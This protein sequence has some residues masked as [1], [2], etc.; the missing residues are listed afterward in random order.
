MIRAFSVPTVNEDCAL[1]TQRPGTPPALSFPSGWQLV[2]VTLRYVAAML[3]Y[4]LRRSGYP[5]FRLR[6]L[7]TL[8]RKKLIA[9]RRIARLGSHYYGT[10]MRIPRWPSRAFDR[11]VA[12]GGLNIE[13]DIIS[14]KHQIDSA[15]LSITRKCSYACEHCSDSVNRHADDIVPVQRWI[16]TVGELQAVGTSVIILSG[17]E[18][19][20]RYPALL[21]ILGSADLNL[22][23]FHL[24]TSGAGVTP[25]RAKELAGKGLVAAG[26][27][28][29]YP[30]AARQDQF[31]GVQG[32]FAA[33][34][35][36]LRLFASA[37]VFTYTNLCLQK[38]L[39]AGNGLYAYL[40]LAKMLNVGSVQL[41]E[42]KPCGKY[43]THPADGLFS[44]ADRTEVMK[45]FIDANQSK[46]FKDYPPVAYTAYYERPE[47]FGCLMGGLS[48]LAIDGNGNVNPCTFVPVSFGNIMNEGFAEVYRRMR[49]VISRPHYG[50]CAS[51]CLSPALA[52]YRL[53][54]GA[55]T[56]HY[57]QFR[58][59][60]QAVFSPSFTET[61]NASKSA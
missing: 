61:H 41:L 11:M 1:P 32:A 39:I 5:H 43:A 58:K 24:H 22:S 19:M 33:A 23:D 3:E 56:V 18:P 7:L 49:G 17:G 60:W 12:N 47:N 21:E 46:Q 10:T 55:Q 44:D 9:I 52:R 4:A 14:E 35:E 6:S 40:D 27:G 28:L 51:V 45:F 48:H 54:R 13:A 53:Q 30:D 38:D 31:R 34:V 42:P 29:D 20:L 59:E 50:T 57:S 2:P 25:A 36:A 26:I 37:G 16:Q 15:I 8:K